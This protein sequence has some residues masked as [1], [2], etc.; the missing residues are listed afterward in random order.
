MIIEISVAV[1]ALAFA[2]LVIYLIGLIRTAQAT[3]R[4]VNQ[5]LN[6][7]RKQLVDIAYEA[8]QIMEHTNEMALGFQNKMESLDPIFRSIEDLGN[9]AESK[10][11]ALKERFITPR[12]I[13]GYEDSQEEKQ[14]VSQDVAKVIANTIDLISRGQRLWQNFNQRR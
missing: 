9:I 14:Q 4:Q 13:N 5:T 1:V 2:A 6:D 12:R 7:S 8:K 10:T 11:T 3:L